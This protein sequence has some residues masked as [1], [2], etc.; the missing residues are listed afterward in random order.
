MS[1]FFSFSFYRCS[2]SRDFQANWTH[3]F[4]WKGQ[5]L[6]W[7]FCYLYYFLLYILLSIHATLLVWSRMLYQFYSAGS[8][9]FKLWLV[10]IRH[11]AILILIFARIILFSLFLLN[12]RTSLSR[13]RLAVVIMTMAMPFFASPFRLNSNWV[14]N[15]LPHLPLAKLELAWK[16]AFLWTFMGLFII[17]PHFDCYS[18]RFLN[19]RYKARKGYL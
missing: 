5:L 6:I 8:S 4:C 3:L 15:T 7:G 1:C 12:A 13:W 16:I 19:H 10:G 9:G 2:Y 11:F 14:L 18:Y 17:F